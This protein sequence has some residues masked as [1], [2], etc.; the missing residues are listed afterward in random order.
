MSEP[1]NKKLYNKVVDEVKQDMKWPSAYASA[2]V[3]KKYKAKGGSYE[4]KPKG[5]LSDA[6]KKISSDR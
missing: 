5:K 2:A 1:K 4:G 3:Q 6:L